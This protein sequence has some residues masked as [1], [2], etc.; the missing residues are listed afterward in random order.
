MK[1]KISSARFAIHS[2][3]GFC[4]C[5]F[6]LIISC[7]AGI[8]GLVALIPAII[9]FEIGVQSLKAL[10]HIRENPLDSSRQDNWSSLSLGWAA[11]STIRQF[12][13][14]VLILII[15]AGLL[16]L[17][18]L[19]GWTWWSLIGLAGVPVYVLLKKRMP[20]IEPL[21]FT[22]HRV[23]KEDGNFIWN[24]H[25]YGS[26][27]NEVHIPVSAVGEVRILDGVQTGE[28]EQVHEA[29]RLSKYKLQQ[30]R[31]LY[32]WQKGEISYPRYFLSYSTTSYISEQYNVLL[33]GPDL[34]WLVA[35]DKATA[36]Q[37]QGNP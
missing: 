2:A 34:F 16:F 30:A 14:L 19:R 24:L 5:I 23:R 18:D 29:A 11:L 36:I 12:T 6:A 28:F 13:A 26:S 17:V 1:K 8:A 32:R 37:L 7:S 15:F 9:G 35:V 27:K 25:I 4:L 22:R 21:C 3:T 20:K 33:S 10:K 31:E